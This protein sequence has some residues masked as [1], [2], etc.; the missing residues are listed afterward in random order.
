MSEN[1]RTRRQFLKA[2]AAGAAAAATA[3]LTAR[4]YARAI[5]ANDRIIIGQIGCGDR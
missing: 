4:S 2:T 3:S 5:G 1:R